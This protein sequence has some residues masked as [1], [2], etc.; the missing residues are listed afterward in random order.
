MHAGFLWQRKSAGL[1]GE[2]SG[3]GGADMGAVG[4]TV[5]TVS[6]YA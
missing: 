4:V 3:G 5:Q 1:L 6:P 2:G